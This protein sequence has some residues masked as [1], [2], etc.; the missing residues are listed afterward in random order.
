MQGLKEV[1]VA[2][3]ALE[4]QGVEALEV[5]MKLE[6][7][8]LKV[9]QGVKELEDLKEKQEVVELEEVVHLGVKLVK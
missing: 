1:M 4:E 5:P 2:E 9:E 3:K 6:L 8:G 7:E